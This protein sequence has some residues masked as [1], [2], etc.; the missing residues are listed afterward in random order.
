MLSLRT[1]SSPT[2]RRRL[3]RLRA[4]DKPNVLNDQS[5]LRTHYIGHFLL[6]ACV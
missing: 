5:D 2:V 4:S 1:S 3:A 6:S